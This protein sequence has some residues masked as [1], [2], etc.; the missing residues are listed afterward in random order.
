MSPEFESSK[1]AL[2]M[3]TVRKLSSFHP[4]E[5]PRREKKTPELYVQ[6]SEVI[7]RKESTAQKQLANSVND[8]TI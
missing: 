3:D 6:L 4:E 2:A 7:E 8:L 5:T 1:P